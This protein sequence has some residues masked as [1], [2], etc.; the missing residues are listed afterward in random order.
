MFGVPF[1]LNFPTEGQQRHPLEQNQ[2]LK[3]TTMTTATEASTTIA[4]TRT[5]CAPIQGEGATSIELD[6][7]WTVWSWPLTARH[8][9]FNDLQARS[10]HLGSQT[11]T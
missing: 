2:A 11:P 8:V 1:N 9:G 6:R 10:T 5:T 7:L 4:T 3:P